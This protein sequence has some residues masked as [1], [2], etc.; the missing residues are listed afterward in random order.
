MLYKSPRAAISRDPSE[1]LRTMETPSLTVWRLNIQCQDGGKAGSFG[2]PSKRQGK[3]K[4]R[5]KDGGR[6]LSRSLFEPSCISGCRCH[7]VA[8]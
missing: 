2:W 7:M 4:K 6:V 1:W 5:A 8:G 3:K